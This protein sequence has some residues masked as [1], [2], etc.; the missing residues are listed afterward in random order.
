[1][2]TV[3]AID[4]FKGS[5]TSMEAGQAIAEGIRRAHIKP[6]YNVP[7]IHDGILFLFHG[8][9]LRIRPERHRRRDHRNRRNVRLRA[10]RP[11]LRRLRRSQR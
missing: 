7:Q 11:Y 3:I 1:M 6:L 2:K 9:L 4:S 10:R 8:R 5:L